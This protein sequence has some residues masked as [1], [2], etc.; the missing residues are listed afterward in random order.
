MVHTVAASMSW[1]QATILGIVEGLTEYLPVSSTG[2]L[3]LAQRAMGMAQTQEAKEA[4]DA[5]AIVIQAGAILAVA[6]LYWKRFVQMAKGLMG[7]DQAGLRLALN[8]GLAFA[9]TGAI[10]LPSEHFVKTYLFDS[11]PAINAAWLAGGLAILA[12]VYFKPKKRGGFPPGGVDSLTLPQAAIIGLMQVLAMWPGTSRS[13][14]TIVAGLLVGLSVSA[15]VEFSFILGVVTLLG[16]TAV[17]LHKH[18]QTLTANYGVFDML[19]GF[20]V[21]GGFAAIAVEWMVTYLKRHSLSL[22]GW[23]RVILAAVV[24]ALM[25]MG[26]LG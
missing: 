2:H 11:I 7:K 14:I 24:G 8:V 13:L 15:A 12:V 6:G 19:L 20:V 21:A 5:Y 3:L 22:F 23:Y 17:E 10:G 18:H 1:W 9:I 4:A 26:K 25:V 16:A